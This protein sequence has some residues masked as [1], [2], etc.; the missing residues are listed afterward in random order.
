MKKKFNFYWIGITALF[1]TS[2]IPN[3]P[4]SDLNFSLDLENK[5][6]QMAYEAGYKKSRDT[7][8]KFF[9]HSDPTV[10]YIAVNAFSSW[11][12]S[13][14]IDSIATLLKDEEET[15]RKGAAYALGQIRSIKAES[16]LIAAFQKFD[17][18]NNNQY[19]NATILEA[20]G[21]CGSVNTLKQISS[22][23]SYKSTDS[24]LVT[25]QARSIYRFAMRE[26]VS[27]EGTK[28][29]I[30]IVTNGAYPHEARLYAANYLSR[31]KG[32]DLRNYTDTLI[33]VFNSVADHDINLA[34]S[35]AI[36]KTKTPGAFAF[37]QT[38]LGRSTDQGIRYNL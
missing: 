8:F 12:D 18:L 27:N 32:I 34:L 1:I 35:A 33:Q 3:K 20:L 25:G 37:V 19:F 4:K 23:K 24:I 11:A 13:S 2:C 9:H 30:N 22:V 26:I 28:A 15:V 16:H 38:E 6:I 17:S 36:S 7:L 14:A 5:D 31:S 10:R 21:K 29:I